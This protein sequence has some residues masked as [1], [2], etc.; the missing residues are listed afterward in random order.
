MKNTLKTVALA[1]ALTV[2]AQAQDNS[3]SVAETT[4]YQEKV[5]AQVVFNITVDSGIYTK[6]AVGGWLNSKKAGVAE[7]KAKLIRT[8]IES[9]KTVKEFD[10]TEVFY[11]SDL[12]LWDRL[13]KKYINAK[14]LEILKQKAVLLPPWDPM[15]SVDK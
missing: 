6:A 5:C 13:I 8:L 15:F 9:Q 2:A 3:L 11:Y 4:V 1:V 7:K 14:T 12:I 10:C